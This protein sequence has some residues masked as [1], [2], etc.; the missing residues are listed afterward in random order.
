MRVF[1]CI[2]HA[3][4]KR[5]N[6]LSY[7]DITLI[8]RWLR[9]NFLSEKL[10]LAWKMQNK[11]M[12]GKQVKLPIL[13]KDQ[14]NELEINL[15][16]KNKQFC[17]CFL[18]KPPNKWK[19]LSYKKHHI[20]QKMALNVFVLHQRWWFQLKICYQNLISFINKKIFIGRRLYK[21]K[22]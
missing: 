11:N 18:Y 20:N 21:K 10:N 7:K 2:F 16:G 12:F 6:L 5:V 13:Q 22:F 8:F 15:Q 1:V 4:E 19:C 3:N 17:L 9:F 14:I